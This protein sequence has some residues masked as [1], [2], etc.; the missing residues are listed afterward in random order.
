[1]RIPVAFS[2]GWRKSGKNS[3]SGEN[4][5]MAGA[6]ILNM[7]MKWIYMVKPPC[8]ESLKNTENYGAWSDTIHSFQ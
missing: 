4:S 8:T 1:M 5:S 6:A 2:A 3:I 7:K